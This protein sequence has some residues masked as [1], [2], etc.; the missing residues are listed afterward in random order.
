MR[1]AVRPTPRACRAGARKQNILETAAASGLFKTLGRALED[2]HLTDM[3]SEAGPF[4]VFAPTDEAFA[5]MPS[6][7]LSALLA[8]KPKLRSVLSRHIVAAK[9]QSAAR[10]RAEHGDLGRRAHAD[11]DRRARLL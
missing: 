11:D 3:L 8:D 7:E 10:T 4:T 2:T 5:K 9:V 1:H 6:G